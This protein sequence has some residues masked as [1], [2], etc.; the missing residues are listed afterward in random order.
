MATALQTR[1]T[2]QRNVAIVEEARRVIERLARIE[3]L[4]AERAGPNALLPELRA[5]VSEAEAWVRVECEVDGAAGALERVRSALGR[6]GASA[7]G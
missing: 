7:H 5:L 2:S 4:E 6:E 3:A 1:A